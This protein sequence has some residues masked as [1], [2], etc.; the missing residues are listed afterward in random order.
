[1][2]LM[3]TGPRN[4]DYTHYQTFKNN[5]EDFA[6]QND[7][8][9]VSGGAQGFDI[10]LAKAAS[11]LNIPFELWFPNPGYI[12]Y[13]YQGKGYSPKN[14]GRPETIYALVGEAQHVN[15]SSSD[16]YITDGASKIHSNFR[17][18]DDMIANSDA[19]VVG[20][21]NLM[22]LTSG[23]RHAVNNMKKI[24][25]PMYNEAFKEMN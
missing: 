17:R 22:N 12:K 23:T 8:T 9:V 25:H 21:L 15:F 14:L 4:W 6:S 3:G 1:M 24:G 2:R 10:A 13:Y 19:A 7:L 20:S 11:E 18:N 16:I 5:L